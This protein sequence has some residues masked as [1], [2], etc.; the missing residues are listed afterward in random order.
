MLWDFS[1]SVFLFLSQ[2]R[3]L[4]PGGTTYE[5]LGFCVFDISYGFDGLRSSDFLLWLSSL[6]LAMS[7][8][9]NMYYGPEGS[10]LVMMDFKRNQAG[11]GW[12]KE[13]GA[14]LETGT[15]SVLII[16]LIWNSGHSNGKS[17]R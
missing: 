5:L 17:S 11:M 10:I 2:L 7:C 12:K 6:L 16:L 1:K 8:Y 15:F 3:C 14:G 13:D 9:D 4:C